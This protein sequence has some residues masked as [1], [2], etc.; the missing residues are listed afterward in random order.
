[1]VQLLSI[2]EIKSLEAAPDRAFDALDDL[3]GSKRLVSSH[4]PAVSAG[5]K[6]SALI[7]VESPA[8][9]PQAGGARRVLRARPHPRPLLLSRPSPALNVAAVNIADAGGYAVLGSTPSTM[10]SNVMR[11]V[12]VLVDAD[13]FTIY[14]A[15]SVGYRVGDGGSDGGSGSG[16]ASA[17]TPLRHYPSR[18][19]LRLALDLVV[20][21]RLEELLAS[22]DGSVETTE[23][24]VEAAAAVET[25]AVEM[26][27]PETADD[28]R[29]QRGDAQRHLVT[30]DPGDMDGEIGSGLEDIGMCGFSDT[31][32]KY[33]L[34]DE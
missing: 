17:N 8:T 21:E 34:N 11:Q 1:M 5:G 2:E 4:V 14:V 29:G 16:S 19:F 3:D 18:L 30:A 13:A 20:L 9:A 23:P 26:A 6:P 12:P 33:E 31:D 7:R 32:D 10:W 27:A 15:S 25:A 24:E 22:T 28:E